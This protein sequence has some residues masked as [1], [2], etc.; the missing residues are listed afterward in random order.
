LKGKNVWWHYHIVKAILHL[1]LLIASACLWA[2]EAADRI[3]ISKVMT[4]LSEA[5]RS[6]NTKVLAALFATDSPKS[7]LDRLSEMDG[8]MLEAS[9]RPWSELTLPH[10]LIKSIRFA[11]PDVAFVDASNRQHGPVLERS[12]PVLFLMKRQMGA[13]KIVSLRV[14]IEHPH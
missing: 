7:E 12:I 11:T 14:V 9:K 1:S 2:D 13:W 3:A 4:A 5:Q 10:I 8:G 6:G